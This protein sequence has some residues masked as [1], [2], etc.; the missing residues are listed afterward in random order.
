YPQQGMNENYTL[1]VYE[2]S[3]PAFL[4]AATVWGALRGL[5]TF[6]QLIFLHDGKYYIRSAHIKDWP[7]YPYRGL[8]IDSGRHFIPKNV[9]KRQ[10]DLLSQNKFNVLHWHVSDSESFPYVSKKFPE[11]AK[12]GAYDKKYMYSPEDVQEI[13]EHARLRGIRVLAEFDTPGHMA[14]WRGIQGLMTNCSKEEPNVLDPSKEST[15]QFLEQF[16]TEIKETFPESWIHLGGDEIH[17]FS[18]CWENSPNVVKFMESKGWGKNVTALV[19]YYFDRFQGIIEKVYG[20]K[21]GDNILMWEEVFKNN[22]PRPN[23]VAHVWLNRNLVAQTT[24]KGHR[25]IVSQGW[26]LDH[27]HGGEDWHDLYSNDPRGFTGSEK[28]KS[29]VIGGE[30]C[31]WGEFID[32]TNLET[33][34]WPRATAV[35]ERLWSNPSTKADEAQARMHEQRCRSLGRG[36]FVRP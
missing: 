17:M 1:T 35:A 5:E 26:Y 4:E 34:V 12:Q 20:T 31:M 10:I 24:A 22:N 36:F 25:T 9:I 16:F 21:N 27:I 11:I 18:Q 19:N 29:L 8:L 3:G 14:S 33:T 28:Q 13:V 2:D 6:S 30:A 15:F 32:A 7:E 23:S